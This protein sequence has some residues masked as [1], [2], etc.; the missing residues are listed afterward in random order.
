M[1]ERFTYLTEKYLDRSLNPAEEAE[2]EKYLSRKECAEYLE[3]AKKAE[4]IIEAGYREMLKSETYGVTPE[5]AAEIEEMIRKYS[6]KASKET[7]DKVSA[8]HREMLRKRKRKLIIQFSS[9]AAMVA[10]AA[11]IFTL[12]LRPG[13]QSLFNDYYKDYVFLTTRGEPGTPRTYSGAIGLYSGGSYAESKEICESLLEQYPDDAKIRFIYGLTL[14]ALDSIPAALEQ[15]NAV[16]SL[17]AEKEQLEPAWAYWYAGLCYLRMEEYDA[18][19]KKLDALKEFT[20]ILFDMEK[21]DK[22]R[23]EILEMRD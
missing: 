6:G 20:N 19:L 16:T 7:R 13:S 8:A 1:D 12:M 18:A 2:F 21:V 22:L 17:K 3:K 10:G 15:F 14:I 11:L 23:G 9:L 5:E 4:A